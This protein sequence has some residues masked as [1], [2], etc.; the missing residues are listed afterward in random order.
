M[1][2]RPYL[3]RGRARKGRG[4][5]ALPAA[6][7]SAATEHAQ[8]PR[9]AGAP[10]HHM[11]A[12]H[13]RTQQ[14]IVPIIVLTLSA[15]TSVRIIITTYVMDVPRRVLSVMFRNCRAGPWRNIVLRSGAVRCGAEWC[16]GGR[17]GAGLGA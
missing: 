7:A 16:V 8:F 10:P 17:G 5:R 12:I 6:H 13:C 14:M 9:G 3:R 11:S 2:E 4:L 1:Y 15:M